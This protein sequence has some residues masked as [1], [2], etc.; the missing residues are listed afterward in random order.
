[1]ENRSLKIISRKINARIEKGDE[2]FLISAIATPEINQ[3]SDIIFIRNENFLKKL[4]NIKSKTCLIPNSLK[5]EVSQFENILISDKPDYSFA[6]LTKIF[7][8]NNDFN[9]YISH[10]FNFV[11][12][13]VIGPG[14]KLSENI[15]IGKNVQIG[16][17]CVI[18]ES[19]F[20]GDN[21]VIDHNV[22]IYDN[23]IIG[24]NN[25]ISSSSVIGSEG[26]GFSKH[27]GNWNH[28][29][30]LGSVVLGDNVYIGSNTCIDKG[31]ISN[32][33]IESN[34]I[35]DN[36][37]HIAHNVHIGDGS[38]IAAKVG[39]AGSTVIGRNCLIG[40]MTGIFGHLKIAD[41]V[42]ITPKSNVYRDIKES[43]RYSSLFPLISHLSW[44][45]IS[46]IISK[47]DKIMKF[48]KK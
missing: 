9:K 36:L 44:K 6:L 37:V 29:C 10:N 28:I 17:N 18:G 41:N 47:I 11:N 22:T 8:I 4:V 21:T 23:V 27:E 38:A 5:N 48:T 45:K 34:V 26:F 19:V 35:I 39:I 15:S 42:V 2:N 3:V 13:P 31:T 32:T 30:H 14:T 12:T 24:K 40:G 20:I 33:V 16:C 1:L 25:H 46:I 43:G 7:A